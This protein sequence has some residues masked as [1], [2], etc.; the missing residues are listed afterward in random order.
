M[1]SQ[2]TEE[3]GER[4][5]AMRTS[6]AILQR[7]TF[8]TSR[9]L[10]FFTEKELSMQIGFSRPGWAIALLRELIDN[11]LDACERAGVAP[12]I[13]VCIDQDTVSVR[14]NGPGLPAS[15]LRDSLDYS[16]R[17]SDKSYY[18]SPTRGQLGNALK[19][20]WAAPYVI[21][22][23][24]GTVEVNANGRAYVVDVQLDRIA[25]VPQIHLSETDSLLVK[26]GTFIKFGWPEIA[27]YLKNYNYGYFY[28]DAENLLNS[29]SSFNPH[30]TFRL[31][32]ISND[33]NKIWRGGADD[34]QRWLPN[35]PTS[36]HWYDLG[37]FV[38]LIGAY[39]TKE[40]SGGQ[41]RSV[42]DFVAEFR[43]LS[44]SAK[45][46]AVT[47]TARLTGCALADL[48]TD[49][50]VDK[51]KASALLW[52]MKNESRAVNP[53]QLGAIGEAHFRCFL[54]EEHL[55]DDPDLIEYRKG[56]GEAGGLPFV[57]EVAFG[58]YGDEWRDYPKKEIIG[59]NWTPALGAPFDALPRLLGEARVDGCDPVV[60]AAHLACPR[61][62]FTDR[63]KSKLALPV[64]IGEAL[65]KCI[66]LVTKRWTAL[67]READKA[68][69]LSERA[70]E[71]Y[72]QQSKAHEL[73]V[74]DAAW[75]VIKDAY[76]KASAG[77]TLPAD[78]RQIMYAAR[79]P[80][81]ALTG[82]PTP[83][84]HSSYFTQK[85]LPDYMDAHPEETKDWDV[86][87]DARGHL[88]EPHTGHRI[89]L[90]TVA[91][92]NYTRSWSVGASSEDMITLSHRFETC[93]PENRYRF[94]LFVEKEGFN[95]LWEAVRLVERFDLA[96]M[97]T[98]GMSVTASRSLVEK[99]SEKDV[100][101][102]VLHDFDKAGFSIVHTLMNDT[103][104]FQFSNKPR[105]IDLGLRLEDVRA[106]NLESEQ[107]EYN[108]D[109][110]P[111]LEQNGATDE[112][113]EYLVRGKSGG[114]WAGERV[115]INAMPSDVLVAWLERK[116][117][118]AGAAKL[119]PSDD[120]LAEAW[121]QAKRRAKVQAAIDKA[122]EEA[123]EADEPMPDGLADKIR[124]AIE[125]K[126][127]SW[128]SALWRLARA[129]DAAQR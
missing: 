19:C 45:R 110:R 86:V 127:E 40:R 32:D 94:A 39:L 4:E 112:E 21:T 126:A 103:R 28:F 37:R 26:N 73:S 13:E 84:K 46:K 108:S 34:F 102:L 87:F 23:E 91:V 90:G 41:V 50:E 109:P 14:D 97:S 65:K 95:H 128:D 82:K 115:E 81:I 70:L 44:G 71:Y 121:K 89:D 7:E 47:D 119:V 120:T 10:E 74:K 9:L 36:P 107:V 100:T 42:R 2:E 11:A 31:N 17:V 62:A 54:V 22:G 43:G 93:G 80:V 77:G 68:N 52:A 61:L 25:Q 76:L 33:G 55:V 122:L 3:N 51:A 20:L 75:Q 83:W 124:E 92:R 96:I 129:E 63:G 49:G 18:V 30:A 88:V 8:S 123:K 98:K 72:R 106:L 85:L 125:G 118:D 27:C 48:V 35:E 60:V 69:R 79:G 24:R 78:A 117:T 5:E 99:L 111:N 113:I 15:T 114:K 64:E 38:S 58:M 16:I 1:A 57:L 67:K 56:E 101:I 105:V 59:L 53:A 29:Y 6:A 66:R 116:L 12:D 104:R